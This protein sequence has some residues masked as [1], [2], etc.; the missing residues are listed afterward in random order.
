MPNKVLVN[1]NL[2]ID[3]DFVGM[4]EIE[5]VYVSSY[6]AQKYVVLKTIHGDSIRITWENGGYSLWKMLCAAS[7][8][9]SDV[10]S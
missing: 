1:D 7:A 2:I 3:L 9:M 8:K 6:T 10:V 4:A 5:N